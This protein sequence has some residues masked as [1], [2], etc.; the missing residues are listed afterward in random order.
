MI[1]IHD[2][3][4]KFLELSHIVGVR[5]LCFD[6]TRAFDCVPHDLL[7]SRLVNLPFT[8]RNILVNWLNSY[9]SNRRQRVKLGSLK[10]SLVDVTSGVPQGSLLGP[11]LFALYMSTFKP[12]NSDVEIVKYAD[13]ITLIVPVFKNDTDDLHNVSSEISHFRSWCEKNRTLINH[14]KTKVLNV[15]FTNFP[16]RPLADYEFVTQVKI[17]GLLFNC[18]L[19]WS[20]HF[21]YVISN[22]SKRLYVLRIL[23]TVLNHDQLV[24][25][26]NAIVRSIM[27]YASPVFL[28]PG[29]L[30][31]SRLEHLCKR[32][33]RIVHGVGTDVCACDKCDM[34]DIHTRRTNLALSLFI[35]A[36][37]NPHHILHPLLPPV[38]H[39]SHRL[40]LP[41]ITTSRRKNGFVF[42]CSEAFNA[43]VKL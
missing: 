34:L 26:F 24:V 40:I 39:R 31:D 12:L 32:A 8:N 16:M 4:L 28:N 9:L 30:L 33:F 15:N 11:F 21:E 6:M 25:V 17:L 42:S 18:K 35:K 1:Y 10:S 22:V 23:S 41:H 14:E 36:L 2:I 13:D 20:D 29:S 43:S 38:S 7:L 27:D 5:I 3:V 19:T 37:H